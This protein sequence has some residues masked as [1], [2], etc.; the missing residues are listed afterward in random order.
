[1]HNC[2]ISA[3]KIRNGQQLRC[4][5]I[6]NIC[7]SFLLKKNMNFL[8]EFFFQCLM[9]AKLIVFQ[10]LSGLKQTLGRIENLFKFSREGV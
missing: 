6:K 5:T 3:S 2:P 9:I 8:S 7:F 10:L 4:Q 1:M